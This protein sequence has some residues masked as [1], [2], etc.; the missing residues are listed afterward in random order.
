[1]TPAHESLRRDAQENRDR[2][3]V[4]ARSVF[5]DV[6]LG[7]SV[8]EIARRAHVG[9]GTL[10]R[11]FET[12]EVLIDAIVTEIL[13]A[14]VA[15]GDR[16]L[17][18][19]SPRDAFSQYLVAS[20]E[21][22]AAHVGFLPRLWASSIEPE[23]RQVEENGRLLLARAQIAG[24]VRPDV[25]YEDLIMVFL[26]LRG[27]MESTELIAAGAW[28]RHLDLILSALMMADIPLTAP[29]LTSGEVAAAKGLSAP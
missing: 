14:I 13:T 26:S 28:R 4:A 17:A 11:R 12:K 27:I 7:A 16:A 8:D 22:Q 23:R 10:Y 25:V 2:I 15:A 20:A 6:G 19:E 5:D 29:P 18:V 24:A 1:M 21:I 3:L 9:V